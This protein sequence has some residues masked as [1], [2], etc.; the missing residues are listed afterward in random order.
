MCV[1]YGRVKN[2]NCLQFTV[3][4]PCVLQMT[5]VFRNVIEWESFEPMRYVYNAYGNM[6]DKM[7]ARMRL[8]LSYYIEPD[9][10]SLVV[11]RSGEA[12]GTLDGGM[13]VGQEGEQI[14]ISNKIMSF[15]LIS[16]S[17]DVICD[18]SCPR[19][20]KFLFWNHGQ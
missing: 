1:L 5:A 13:D 20:N 4:F 14:I 7:V 6:A 12:E 9:S 2:K 17:K 18:P 8:S 19:T 10:G 16:A 15:R 11:V 3:A